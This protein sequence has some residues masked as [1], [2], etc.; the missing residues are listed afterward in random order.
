LP[1]NA[2]LGFI[3]PG[4]PGGQFV[5][6]GQQSGDTPLAQTLRGHCRQFYFGNIKSLSGNKEEPIKEA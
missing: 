5:I 6:H 4:M 1:I 2:F 3:T